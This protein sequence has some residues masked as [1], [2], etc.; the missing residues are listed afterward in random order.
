MNRML[1]LSSNLWTLVN[2]MSCSS[3]LWE[4]PAGISITAG[5]IENRCWYGVYPYPLRVQYARVRV[6]CER[7][8]PAVYPWQ[9]LTV[10]RLQLIGCTLFK[11]LHL[12]FTGGRIRSGEDNSKLS[13]EVW[14]GK[15]RSWV[16]K[17]SPTSLDRRNGLS[18]CNG[19]IG[20][21]GAI[22]AVCS[23]QY[24]YCLMSYR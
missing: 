17:W 9:T 19:A 15:S 12:N 21:I 14:D 22:C 2:L 10:M 24:L 20:T 16:R 3:L 11:S 1:S 18:G 13:S 7:N 5:F 23:V 4:S 6:R 8:V